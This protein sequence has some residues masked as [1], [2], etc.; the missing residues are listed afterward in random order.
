MLRSVSAT[1]DPSAL[2]GEAVKAPDAVNLCLLLGQVLFGFGATA[3]RIQDSIA[4]L[5]RHL[6][7]KVDMLVSYDALLITVNDGAT[8]QTRIDSARRLAVLDLLGLARVTAWLL[9]LP[10]SQTS[11]GQFEHELS[12]I[13][14]TPQAYRPAW[15]AL[16]AGCA[17]VAFCIVN[18]GDPASWFGSFAAAA[19]IF[20][21]RRQMAARNFNVHL[22]LFAVSFT[23]S[24]LGLLLGRLMQ[25]AT[26]TI[27]LGAPVLFLVPGVPMING[28]I[29][30]VRNHVT[31]GIARL[32]FTLAALVSLCLGVGLTIPMLSARMQPPFSLRGPWEIVLFSVAG[33][34]GAGALACLNNGA[35]PVI[36]LCALGGL[37]GRLVR[38]LMSLSGLDPITAS[39]AGVLCSTL[40]VTIVADRYRWPAVAA[41]VMAAL[42]MV[43]GYFA[44]AGM[45]AL[46]SFAAANAADPSQLS[47]GVHAL[48]RALFI[49]V[50]LVVGVIGP[51]ITLQRAKER[52]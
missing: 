20:A 16:T 35:F 11:A 45:H 39:L 34:L 29:D 6:G 48:S 26:P 15:H 12:A 5:A 27:A 2:R 31:I 19:A 44:I 23:G 3:Q 52:V 9:G 47:A 10:R 28:G 41:S 32:G 14:D 17:G 46:L 24:L 8:F 18:G 25:T 51:V 7:C 43:P 38:A 42:P 33:A 37:T 50:A 4:Y 49:S 36:A 40:A 22:T 30:I 13:R 1:P 21:L